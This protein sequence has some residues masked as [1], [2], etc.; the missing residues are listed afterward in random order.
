MK[1][2]TDPYLANGVGYIYM[3]SSSYPFKMPSKS[4]NSKNSTVGYTLQQIYISYQRS[5][6]VAFLMYNDEDPSGTVLKKNKNTLILLGNSLVRAVAEILGVVRGL[7]QS[8]WK[9]SIY[10]FYYSI[11]ELEVHYLSIKASN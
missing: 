3:D 11:A 5:G 4:I 1:H 2:S 7:L 10:I 6:D 8:L 9:L